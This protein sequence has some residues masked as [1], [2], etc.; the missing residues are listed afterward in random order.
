MK[1][2][3]KWSKV[4][5][6][7]GYDVFYRRHNTLSWNQVGSRLS[8]N[9]LSVDITG[10]EYNLLY[11]FQVISVCQDDRLSPSLIQTQAALK[12]LFFTLTA[13]DTKVKVDFNTLGGDV[14][15]YVIKLTNPAG[16]TV[17][18]VQT[19]DV[20]TDQKTVSHTF[21][22][23]T[24]A[25]IYGVVIDALASSVTSTSPVK[26]VETTVTQTDSTTVWA[27]VS[28]LTFA[29]NESAKQ[30]V[31]N[32][33][34]TQPNST[35]RVDV[36]KNLNATANPDKPADEG[37]QMHPVTVTTTT[38][39]AYSLPITLPDSDPRMFRSLQWGSGK[40]TS[41]WKLFG[42]MSILGSSTGTTVAAPSNLSVTALSGALKLNWQDNSNN[43]TS[44][45]VYRGSN[46]GELRT[47]TTLPAGTTT[48]TDTGV[49]SGTTYYY[50]L[51]A[52]K[53]G[54][55]STK[56]N[57]A[58]GQ[59]TS[60]NPPVNVEMFWQSDAE[61]SA[62]TYDLDA[63]FTRKNFSKELS[64]FHSTKWLNHLGITYGEPNITQFGFG[65]M[66][67]MFRKDKSYVTEEE[68]FA[69]VP[70]NFR[71][72][73]ISQNGTTTSG[74][75]YGEKITDPNA[76]GH[77]QTFQTID[78]PVTI[79]LTDRSTG[80]VDADYNYF[81]VD[82]NKVD[83]LGASYNYNYIRWDAEHTPFSYVYRKNWLKRRNA[84]E[85]GKYRTRA[86]G[87]TNPAW[88][89]VSDEEWLEKFFDQGARFGIK[90]FRSAYD[91][92]KTLGF[93]PWL[94]CY[95]TFGDDTSAIWNRIVS[96][97]GEVQKPLSFYNTIGHGLDKTFGHYYLKVTYASAEDNMKFAGLDYARVPKSDKVVTGVATFFRMEQVNDPN[98]QF[99]R[100]RVRME[101]DK[102]ELV[103]NKDGVPFKAFLCYR[104]GDSM[105]YDQIEFL[106]SENDLVPD[107]TFELTKAPHLDSWKIFS[108]WDYT[109]D[110]SIA[111]MLVSSHRERPK[112][113]KWMVTQVYPYTVA[114]CGI[115]F[116][117]GGPSQGQCEDNSTGSAS[118]RGLTA[119]WT[120]WAT[121]H[122]KVALWQADS[123]WQR[124]TA[125][126]AVNYKVN[127]A[128]NA[129][130][131]ALR[132]MEHFGKYAD[133]YTPTDNFGSL[134]FEISYN[135]GVTWI[136][137]ANYINSL[138]EQN[139]DVKKAA[140][141]VHWNKTQGK[142]LI[143]GTPLYT[144]SI[145]VQIRYLRP[146]GVQQ[147]KT[148]P[149]SKSLAEGMYFE[150]I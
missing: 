7:K 39:G 141:K 33:K 119:L 23:L 127:Y 25:T 83:D 116:G 42:P 12:P 85:G 139:S 81:L 74:H 109:Q 143:S 150:R 6:P 73:E 136:S 98:S 41:D 89:D 51:Y 122:I 117:I 40:Q 103:K 10:L 95:G 102:G 1:M 108:N 86:N 112:D 3:L 133:L 123:G 53:D 144:D 120:N 49:V 30:I 8:A 4:G 92:I 38:P 97:N 126:P 15:R 128:N 46:Q 135:G 61:L 55:S 66:E 28:D 44:F 11:D 36:T 26:T 72:R 60:V 34:T 90:M 20:A 75:S 146:D 37:W 31:L 121:E 138:A 77:G 87:G 93:D 54:T 115:M 104:T 68:Y 107:I 47:Y 71:Y 16:T 22:G 148:L 124:A 58:S 67:A 84:W 63:H 65:V 134:E 59:I 114:N 57:T 105:A 76:T 35:I 48:Y 50:E 111:K 29:P 32:F 88:M 14:S 24:S 110:W 62:G 80:E 125:G 101:N 5:D 118:A 140:V 130:I 13:E 45:A 99:P 100:V 2:T 43:E 64:P 142:G 70:R 18:T 9:A 137:H 131:N 79:N 56:S 106:R 69:T 147:V 52:L 113:G 91:R 145:S 27:N 21:T 78:G 94:T 19:V 17:Q 96:I 132:A 82:I 149:L 129:K